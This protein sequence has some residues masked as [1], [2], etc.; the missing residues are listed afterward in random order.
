MKNIIKKTLYLLATILIGVFVFFQL[1]SNKAETAKVTELATQTGSFYP[2]K[3]MIVQMGT[4]ETQIQINGFLQ[5]VTDL[6]VLAETQGVIKEVFKEKGDFVVK[7]DIIAQVDDELLAAQL[8]A[9]K[10]AYQQLNREVERFTKLH[11]QNAVTDQKLE[12]IKLNFE[13]A[14]ASYIAA[15][16][17][18]DD[19]K[20]KAPVGGFIEN[21]FIEK[22]QYIS[23]NAQICNII[24][25]KK[26][27]LKV[28]VSEQDYQHIQLGQKVK[29]STSVY[30]NIEF[31]GEISYIG[32]KAGFGNTFDADI[33]IINDERNRL[34]AGMFVTA[35]LTLI[36][37]TPGIYIPRKAINGSLKDASVYTIKDGVANLISVTTGNIENDQV[38]IT[39]GLVSG[40]QI[41]TQGNYSIFDG[42]KVKV[43]D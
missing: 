24:D 38:E 3:A 29:I 9:S 31:E 39:S 40:S 1:R 8:S 16:R 4:M 35:T 7:G 42:A 6:D 27:K 5:S 15:K 17:Q 37:S 22:G 34:K 2:V 25:A 32:K 43:M 23:R 10:A 28:S 33:T 13:S 12:E 14:E 26:L 30:S 36:N 20:I 11:A 21:D 41:V 18:Y 19:T